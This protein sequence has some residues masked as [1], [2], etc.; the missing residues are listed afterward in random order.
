MKNLLK[1]SF[2]IYVLFCFN[3]YAL[4]KDS[5]RLSIGLGQFN[6]MEDGTPPHKNQSQMINLEVPSGKKLFSLIKP[7]A[8]FLGTNKTPTMLMEVCN[9]WLLW[10]EEKFYINASSCMWFLKMEEIKA[11]IIGVYIG[12]DAFYKFKNNVRLGLGVSYI[13]CR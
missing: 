7:F 13:Q 11:E 10:K 3:N 9:R 6:F 8:G 1:I 4:S 5:A 12:I 2:F